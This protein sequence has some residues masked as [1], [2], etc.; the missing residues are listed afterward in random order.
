MNMLKSSLAKF[1]PTSINCYKI[2]QEAWQNDKILVLT[3]DQQLKLSKLE[4]GIIKE[5]ADRL[6]KG[7]P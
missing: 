3:P 5:V 2:K 7:N 4:Y 1:M 6:Y